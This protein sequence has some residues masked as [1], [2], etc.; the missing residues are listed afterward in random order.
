MLPLLQRPHGNL[1]WDSAAG[2]AVLFSPPR[3]G[4][5]HS[6]LVPAP[7]CR[8]LLASHTSDEPTL[9]AAGRF[10]L[11]GEDGKPAGA[12]GEALLVRTESGYLYAGTRLP[13]RS[14]CSYPVAHVIAL[15]SSSPQLAGLAGASVVELSSGGP[16]GQALFVLILFCGAHAQESITVD[17]CTALIESELGPSARPDGVEIFPLLPRRQGGSPDGGIDHAWVC[18]QYLLGELHRKSRSPVFHALTR[19]R[20]ALLHERK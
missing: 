9:T 3:V 18:A 1:I 20:T 17:R 5:L 16:Q 2:G 19:A 13:R 11:I 7:G 10:I 6:Q 8:H 15:L 12:P 14:G 4:P